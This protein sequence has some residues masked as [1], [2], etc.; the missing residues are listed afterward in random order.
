MLVF[1][2]LYVAYMVY[3]CVH[4]CTQLK[5]VIMANDRIH[6]RTSP[7]LKIEL[8]KKLHRYGFK[9]LSDLVI[10]LLMSWNEQNK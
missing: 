4:L 5:I 1:F 8:V 3:L 9:S 10:H 7:V 2:A 6:V